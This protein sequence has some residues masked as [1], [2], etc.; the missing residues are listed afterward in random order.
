MA[1]PRWARSRS[2]R[3]NEVDGM[4]ARRLL[5]GLAV[6]ATIVAATGLALDRAVPAR[7]VALPGPVDRGR[8]RQRSPAACLHHG[9]TA[10]G[11]SRRRSMM[12][13][14]SISACSRPTR[15]AASTIIGASIRSPHV[16]RRQAARRARPHRLGRLDAL[17]AGRPPARS[18]AAQL[19]DQG[20]PV[21]PRAAARVALLQARGA[22]DLPDAG[23]DGRQSRR[24]ARRLPRLFRQ[25][26]DASSAPPKQP[27]SSPSR[28]RPNAAGPIAPPPWRRRRATACWCAASSTA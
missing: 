28:N 3:R 10:S 5:V 21:G 14:R 15:I 24:R 19:H 17:D 22:G 12:S 1:G 7:P 2:C 18:E 4:N 20:D 13:I 16:A 23:A 25:G 6:V 8:R 27:C 26:A 9:R 11:G